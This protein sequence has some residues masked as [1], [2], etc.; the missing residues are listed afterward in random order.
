M[1]EIHSVLGPGCEE[2]SLFLALKLEGPHDKEGGR[3]LGAMGA[4]GLT[5]CQ[6]MA[7]L[8]PHLQG[9]ESCHHHRTLEEDLKLQMRMQP[10]RH[11]L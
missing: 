5:A 10:S 9:A 4:P 11:I 6:E 7:T 2:D 1:G 3:P 8:I